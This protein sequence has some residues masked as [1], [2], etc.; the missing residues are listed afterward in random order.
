MLEKL[1]LAP[2]DLK[3][4][5]LTGSFGGQLN[6]DS[7]LALGMLPSISRKRIENIP[8]GAGFGAAQFLSDE[9][10][11]LGEQLAKFAEQ[12]DLDQA[13]E[14]REVFV[15]SLQFIAPEAIL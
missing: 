2:T 12:I 10:L 8:N 11:E 3:Q 9:G 1:G 14:F 15:E 4:V 7:V 6:I 13:A 5:I